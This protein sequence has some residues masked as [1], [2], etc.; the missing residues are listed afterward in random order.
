MA[1]DSKKTRAKRTAKRA[2]KAKSKD[3]LK[4]EAVL[5]QVRERKYRVSE[6]ELLKLQKLKYQGE[7]IGTKLQAAQEKLAELQVKAQTASAR[8]QA[9]VDR[10]FKAHGFEEWFSI[11]LSDEESGGLVTENT[12]LKKQLEAAQDAASK[13]S[14]PEGDKDTEAP[15]EP[16][17]EPA[18]AA[19][20]ASGD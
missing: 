19:E 9:E 20:E 7:A 3:D 1:R 5:A 11:D 12:Q 10:V 2:G 16:Q 8:F 6:V 17:E 4:R 18:P 13:E 15:E 14:E